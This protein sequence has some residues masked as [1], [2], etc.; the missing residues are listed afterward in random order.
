[1]GD[2]RGRRCDIIRISDIHGAIEGRTTTIRVR[3]YK[4]D[5]DLT[6]EVKHFRVKLSISDQSQQEQ[7]N[8]LADEV[9]KRNDP[10][11]VERDQKPNPDGSANHFV[12]VYSEASRPRRL[13]PN[14]KAFAEIQEACRAASSS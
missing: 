10:R 6:G 9:V 11:F 7:L 13:L 3:D 8:K 4:G 2:G 1:M 14:E 12:Q 5:D